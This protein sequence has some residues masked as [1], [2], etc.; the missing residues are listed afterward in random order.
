ME[1][2]EKKLED[3]IPKLPEGRI[4]PRKVRFAGGTSGSFEIT[5]PRDVIIREANKLKIEF[6]EKKPLAEQPKLIKAIER[7][8]EAIWVYDN[9][10]GYRLYLREKEE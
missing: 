5:I 2:V 9:F 1:K 10:E 6:N 4:L 3:K 7:M 8:L